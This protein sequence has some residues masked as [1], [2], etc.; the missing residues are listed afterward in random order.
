MPLTATF[1]WHETPTEVVLDV[2]LKGCSPDALDVMGACAKGGGDAQIS[3]SSFLL[4]PPTPAVADVAVKVSFA[5]YLIVV[6]L[7][8]SVLAADVRLILD[9]SSGSVSLRLPKAEATVWGSLSLQAEGGV[10]EARRAQSFERE[11]ERQRRAAVDR[12]AATGAQEREAMRQQMAV[13]ERQRSVLVQRQQEEKETAQADAVATLRHISAM[14]ETRKTPFPT[15]PPAPRVSAELTGDDAG[16]PP[17]ARPPA[18]RR[19][20]ALLLEEEPE[21][22][23]E[24]H[25]LPPRATQ[26]ITIKFTPR[27][28]PTPLR[29]SRA[30]EEEDWLARN[31]LRL[32]AGSSNAPDRPFVERDPAWLKDKGNGFAQAGDWLSAEAAYS[33]S[34]E[35]APGD[36]GTLL[37][38][39]LS[40]LHVDRPGPCVE[41]C[42]TAVGKVLD[43]E[44]VSKGTDVAAFVHAH[45]LKLSS[46]QGKPRTQVLKAL[47]RCCLAR[48]RAGTFGLSLDALSPLLSV[49]G[50][51]EV[52]GEGVRDVLASLAAAERDKLGGDGRVRAG[53]VE[54]ALERY[55]LA[56]AARP[57]YVQAALNKAAALHSLTR[58]RQC[59][60]ACLVAQAALAGAQPWSTASLDAHSLGACPY[61]GTALYQQCKV[62]VEARLADCRTR[63]EKVGEATRT[64]T[65]GEEWG[66]GHLTRA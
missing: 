20:A 8:H 47:G 42:L 66:E 58:W 15:T 11:L 12:S 14:S 50:Q 16:A 10:L 25:L 19:Q 62:R 23:Q 31:Y 1:S 56:L 46:L 40:R 30:R 17:T 49:D 55:D 64:Q 43:I 53:D 57:T 3:C 52:A 32:K 13:E 4:H 63:L 34:L 37:N 48:L 38:R 44:M 2:P 7:L 39:A 26:K 28:F 21:D 18:P 5:P 54:G 29:E 51:R 33:A 9:R 6:D 35:A 27:S 65:V 59:E 61:A 41:D 36:V 60:G 24:R 22:K 45:A